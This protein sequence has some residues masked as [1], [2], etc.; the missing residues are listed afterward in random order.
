MERVLFDA[1]AAEGACPMVLP[2]PLRNKSDHLLT[3]CYSTSGHHLV[4]NPSTKAAFAIAT[5]VS[6]PLL[7][8]EGQD[9]FGRVVARTS[10]AES[11][12]AS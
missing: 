10:A 6:T 9:G 7:H 12:A 4:P 3:S 2:H 5:I 11:R 8:G 1:V